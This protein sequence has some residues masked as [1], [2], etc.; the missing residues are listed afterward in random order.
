MGRGVSWEASL[1]H[2]GGNAAWARSESGDGEVTAGRDGAVH[3]G[4]ACR[5]SRWL[6]A[7]GVRP[8]G[9]LRRP[10]GKPG[11]ESPK[12][13]WHSVS[14]TGGVRTAGVREERDTGRGKCV[15]RLK[16]AVQIVNSIFRLQPGLK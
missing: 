9:Q 7:R 1:L 13:E 11:A 2:L 6:G 14:P 5:P 12:P 10:R 15:I 4:I 8:R 16:F 3:G